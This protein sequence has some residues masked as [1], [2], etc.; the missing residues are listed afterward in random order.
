MTVS[1][2]RHP[3]CG[4]TLTRVAVTHHSARGRCG[5][6]WLRPQEARLVPG[7]ATNL[8]CEPNDSTPSPL[9]RSAVAQ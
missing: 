1:A 3:L 7:R 8:A 2:P 5:V 6:V 9:A 4:R